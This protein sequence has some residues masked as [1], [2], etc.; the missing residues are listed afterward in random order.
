[1]LH[2]SIVIIKLHVVIVVYFVLCSFNQFYYIHQ[3]TDLSNFPLLYPQSIITAVCEGERKG[4]CCVVCVCV[5]VFVNVC[6][7]VEV[8]GCVLVCACACGCVD[9]W[10]GGSVS[11]CICVYG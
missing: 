7:C 6:G 5:C 11:V 9:V 3:K 8:W 4:V 1:M 2:S 10:V